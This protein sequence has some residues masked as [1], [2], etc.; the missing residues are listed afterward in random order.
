MPKL[1]QL[2]TRVECTAHAV[3]HLHSWPKQA[4]QEPAVEL[5]AQQL[6]PLAVEAGAPVEPQEAGPWPQAAA[7]AWW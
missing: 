1:A 4:V 3:G 2:T 6:Q 5:L 7:A